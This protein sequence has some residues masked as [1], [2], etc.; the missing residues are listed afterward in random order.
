MYAGAVS[1]VCARMFAVYAVC[2]YT[3]CLSNG[4]RYAYAVPVYVFWHVLYV[5]HDD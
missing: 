4:G 1:I 2:I 5:L 3:V